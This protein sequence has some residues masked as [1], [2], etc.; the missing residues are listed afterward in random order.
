MRGTGRTARDIAD[1]IGIPP[2]TL[3]R[4]ATGEREPRYAEA[5]KIAAYFGLSTD[6]L[7]LGKSSILKEDAPAYRI[8]DAAQWKQRALE[9]ELKFENLKKA[10]TSIIK[11]L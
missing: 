8:D 5:A 4:Y 1:E 6:S 9:A 11:D 2:P 3:S 10:L 7:M